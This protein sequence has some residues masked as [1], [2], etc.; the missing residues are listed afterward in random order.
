MADMMRGVPGPGYL[1]NDRQLYNTIGA[2]NCSFT[3]D[4]RLDLS[5][6]ANF[7][8]GSQYYIHGFCDK[9]KQTKRK[10]CG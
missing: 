6:P 5:A 3:S 1:I 2:T 4:H 7:N 8:P 10:M 9:Y